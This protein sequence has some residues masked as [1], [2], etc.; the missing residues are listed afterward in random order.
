MCF[1]PQA[2]RVNGTAPFATPTP[3]PCQPSARISVTAR[4]SPRCARRTPSSSADAMMTRNMIMAAGSYSR[5]ATL[6]NMYDAPQSRA[7]AAM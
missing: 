2:I 7:R 4:L 3:K 6:M 1:S 5:T